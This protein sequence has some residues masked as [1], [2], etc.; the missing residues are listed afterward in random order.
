[1]KYHVLAVVALTT[2]PVAAHAADVAAPVYD[3]SGFYLGANAGHTISI[4]DHDDV[5]LTGLGNVGRLEVSGAY[6][7]LQA[8][9]NLQQD[10]LMLGVETDIQLSG[11]S[12]SDRDGDVPGFT[13]KSDVQ[14]FTTARLRGG[15]AMDRLL[16]YGTGGFI[17]AGVDYSVEG[18]GANI[19]N[20]YT[21]YGYVLGAGVEY[22]VSDS[23]SVKAEYLHATFMESKKLTD[24][25]TNRSTYAAPDFESLRIGVN[26]K[27]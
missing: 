16:V 7:G 20:S 27:F 17:A 14:Y 22:A 4:G 18:K 1:M 26:F 24:P 5:G 3:W 9:Y 2:L 10:M 8:G 12:D 11:V 15:V 23:W 6:G 13:S 19:D 25:N 21:D